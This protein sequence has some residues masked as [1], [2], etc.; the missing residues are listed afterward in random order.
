MSGVDGDGASP[1]SHMHLHVH[2]RVHTYT[3]IRTLLLPHCR[4]RR[5]TLKVS[6][7]ILL[8]DITKLI[9]INTGFVN[10]Y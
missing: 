5:H 9:F 8:T 2:S 4:P 10:L 6:N 1:S 3:H 7:R